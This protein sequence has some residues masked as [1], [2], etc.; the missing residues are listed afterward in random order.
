M[1]NLAIVGI[2]MLVINTTSL[3]NNKTEIHNYTD[4]CSLSAMPRLQDYCIQKAKKEQFR[5]NSS[6]NSIAQAINNSLHFIDGGLFTRFFP[7]SN[8][9]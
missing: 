4:T 9:N 7:A 1:K 5:Y 6:S 2:V 3:E 8:K